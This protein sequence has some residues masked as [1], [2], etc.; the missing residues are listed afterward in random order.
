M[1]KINCGVAGF[2]DI[3]VLSF[4]NITQSLEFE[5]K[6][7]QFLSDQNITVEKEPKQ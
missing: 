3:L 6:F 2:G 1:L 7:L 5:E 4:G